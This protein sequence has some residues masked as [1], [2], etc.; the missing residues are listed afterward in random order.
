[1]ARRAH[2][3]VR[4]PRSHPGTCS[5]AHGAPW[6]HGVPGGGASGRAPFSELSLK[7]QQV[8]V[9]H[10]DV[11]LLVRVLHRCR[12]RCHPAGEDRH[13]AASFR[14]TAHR[15]TTISK[16]K[17]SRKSEARL[18]LGHQKDARMP[19]GP[20]VAEDSWGKR[21]ISL[22]RSERA[23][24]SP[25][26]AWGV[27][28]LFKSRGRGSGSSPSAPRGRGG[29]LACSVLISAPTPCC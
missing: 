10:A 17:A 19:S 13:L 14:T 26:F 18:N 16:G 25:S 27:F 8:L 15:P 28:G 5:R 7:A 12:A 24:R 9:G 23:G 2:P 11:P 21:R 6:G 29:R 4:A 20:C 22:G 3:A 1:M